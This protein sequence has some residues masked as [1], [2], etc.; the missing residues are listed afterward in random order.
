MPGRGANWG[1]R[2]AAAA[3]LIALALALGACGNAGPSRTEGLRVG[4]V[5]NTLGFGTRIEE[6]Q[7]RARATGA[8]WL[9]EEVAWA[10]IE[11]VPGAR[12]WGPFDRMFEGAAARGLHV[13]PLLHDA[14]AWAEPA[15]RGMPTDAAAFAAFTRDAVARYGPAGS[16]W[17]SRPQLDG[18]LAPRWFELWNEPFFAAPEDTA[19][20]ARRYAALVAAAVA[21]GRAA[22]PQTRY[23]LALDTSAPSR[24]GVDERWLAHLTRA[25]PGL[26]G[27]VDGAAIHPY[28]FDGRYGFTPLTGVLDAL[29]RRGAELPLWVTEV[30]WSTCRGEGGCVSETTQAALLGAFLAGVAA[31]FRSQVRA[32]FVYH[33]RD[34]EV[35]VPGG[36][37]GAFGLLRRDHSRKPAWEVFR[38]FADG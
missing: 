1:G 8:R 14:P 10:E 13:L 30:G 18:S 4:L 23:L 32:V 16:F 38:R 24:P 17:R 25:R 20:S 31:D 22:D 15:D 26:L 29:R 35:P 2:A 27:L 3:L 37:E 21:A 12:R 34:F 6:E 28:G 19:T 9:R 11:P 7:D 36:R 33:L 5:A